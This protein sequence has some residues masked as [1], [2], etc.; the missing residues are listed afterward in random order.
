MWSFGCH[1]SAGHI[2]LFI[3]ML[4]LSFRRYWR[5]DKTCSSVNICTSSWTDRDIRELTS[6]IKYL[7]Q[8]EAIGFHYS[9]TNFTED[10]LVGAWP[11]WLSVVFQHACIQSD[12]VLPLLEC[13]WGN[14]YL[15]LHFLP[16]WFIHVLLV[17]AFVCTCSWLSEPSVYWSAVFHKPD[18][19]PVWYLNVKKYCFSR[20]VMFIMQPLQWIIY[21]LLMSHY[22]VL[23]IDSCDLTD[24]E[25][26]L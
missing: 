21:P 8:T 18:K 14:C 12:R 23:Q 17:A 2:E 16:I 24:R 25:T 26:K 10:L 13:Q 1:Y 20:N 15:F 7:P 5:C 9:I 6:A 3:W 4:S 22:G 19:R 11:M